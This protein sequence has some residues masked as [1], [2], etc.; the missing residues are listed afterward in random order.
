M[1]LLFHLAAF[2][3]FHVATFPVFHLSGFLLSAFSPLQL[4]TR[5][6]LLSIRDSPPS[7]T[8]APTL[9][10]PVSGVQ[11]PPSAIGS[12][13]F[14]LQ[15]PPSNFYAL[16]SALYAPPATLR[17][18][19]ST[20]HPSRFTLIAPPAALAVPP[21]TVRLA[22]P[23]LHVPPSPFYPRVPPST[24]HLACSA[25]CPRRS[26]LHATPLTPCPSPATLQVLTPAFLR[27]W[28]SRHVPP[29]ISLWNASV[30]EHLVASPRGMHR[31]C[32][33]SVVFFLS[34]TTSLRESRR[35]D[36]SLGA[37]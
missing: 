8:S 17:G 14:R 29:S 28:S 1:F 33:Q 21:F 15:A 37:L 16:P 3:P 34:G 11:A 30:L 10:S 4:P 24:F 12:P 18:P 36:R 13:R 23:A 6:F 20:F 27:P 25:R 32:S 35:C 26:T 5:Q 9:P 31:E 7:S 22:R 2:R 19:P